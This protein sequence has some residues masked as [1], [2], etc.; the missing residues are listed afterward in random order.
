MIYKVGI[1]WLVFASLVYS[2]K[3]SDC[4]D[5]I[6]TATT[7]SYSMHYEWICEEVV[8][9][10]KSMEYSIPVKDSSRKHFK[11]SDG[12]ETWQCEE[13]VDQMHQ[14]TSTL[15][16]NN[17]R[18]EWIATSTENKSLDQSSTKT[19]LVSSSTFSITDDQVERDP[20]VDGYKQVS[21]IPSLLVIALMAMM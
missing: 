15:S 17:T 18:S 5:S 19:S 7:G 16:L 14:Q 2:Y 11:M 9:A 4:T 12:E 21:L 13:V 6:P 8:E 20:L 3:T 1:S 10:Q